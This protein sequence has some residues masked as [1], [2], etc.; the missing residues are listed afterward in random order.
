[1][2]IHSGHV[3]CAR[4]FP[5]HPGKAESRPQAIERPSPGATAHPQRLRRASKVVTPAR[6]LSLASNSV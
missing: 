4:R 2:S 5:P 6:V 1:L 3:F